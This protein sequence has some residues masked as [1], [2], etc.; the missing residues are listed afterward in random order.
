MILNKY[1]IIA[2]DIDGTIKGET[3][4][5]SKYTNNVIQNC[6]E[7]GAI[8]VLA[9]GRSFKSTKQILDQIKSI[10]FVISFQGAQINEV[11][12]RFPI[13]NQFLSKDSLLNATKFYDNYDVQQIAYVEEDIYVK[14]VTPWVEAYAQRNNVIMH[15]IEKFAQIEQ[16]VIR[17]LAVGEPD[18]IKKIDNDFQ[19]NFKYNLYG[20][21][22]LPHFFEIL[23]PYAGKE[24]AL[25][26][27]CQQLRLTSDH[28]IA[29]GNGFNDVPML[30][31]A[32]ASVALENGSRDALIAANFITG[33]VDA[34][35]VAHFISE[36]I[37]NNMIGV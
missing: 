33:P 1:K 23:S 9:T 30:K 37:D 11:G 16:H 34:D 7:L 21:R 20:T 2:L 19:L 8:I 31:W 22:S 25:D 5:V 10:S 26:F 13:W 18:L 27:L 17:V 36:M 24:K 4:N 3:S 12:M 29:F 14:E 35:G 28:V 15:K 32:G 6:K